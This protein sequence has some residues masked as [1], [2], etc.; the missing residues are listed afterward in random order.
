MD[1][2]NEACAR[3]G[4]QC[5]FTHAVAPWNAGGSGVGDVL[6]G[7]VKKTGAGNLVV[8]HRGLSTTERCV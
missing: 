7:I 1:A 2:V 3:R 8:G 6:C 5:T 4:R